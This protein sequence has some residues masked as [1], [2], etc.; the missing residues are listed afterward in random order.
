MQL[1]DLRFGHEPRLCGR[2]NVVKL[3][4]RSV[5]KIADLIAA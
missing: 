5:V 2:V 1:P 4:S 3:D